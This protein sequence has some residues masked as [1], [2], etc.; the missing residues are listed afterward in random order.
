MSYLNNM[1]AVTTTTPCAS[2][3]GSKWGAYNNGTYWTL[4][5]NDTIPQ[6][7]DIIRCIGAYNTS[8]SDTV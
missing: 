6:S 5:S 7:G 8:A 3:N 2:S 4:D 1:P